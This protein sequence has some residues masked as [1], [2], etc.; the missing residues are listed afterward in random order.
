VTAAR[1]APARRGDVLR[2]TVLA[3]LAAAPLSFGAVHEAA[4]VPL[5]VVA[6]VLGVA[7]WLRARGAGAGAG[8]AEPLPGARALLAMHGLVLLQLVPLPPRALALLSPGSFSFYNDN[9]ALPLT[10]WRPVSVSPPD[11]LRGLLF[12]AGMSCL[13]AAVFREFRATRWRRRLCGTLV[14]VAFVMT[15]VALVQAAAGTTRIYGLFQ[16]RWDWAVFGPYV[17]KNHFAG[18][19]VLA[20]PLALAFAAEAL[21]GLRAAWRR[22]RVGWLAL[23]EAEGNAAIRRAAEAMALMVGLL[24]SRSRGGLVAFVV[25]AASFPLA[26]RRR[27]L[28][29]LVIALVTLLGTAWV[30]LAGMVSHFERR[31]LRSSRLQLWGDVLR[32][33][34]PFLPLGS[35]LNG[36]GILYPFHQTLWRGEWYGEAHNEYLQALIDMGL[37]G[38]LLTLALVSRLLKAAVRAAPLSALDAGLLGSVIAS[39]A[40]AL[41]DFNWQIPANAATFVA[42]A[43]LVLGGEADRARI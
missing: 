37:P 30:G 15:I 1:A 16:P 28:A 23:G 26:F 29:V 39:C 13:Y 10:E 27:R 24:A 11:T 18:Y 33:A 3:L 21:E 25:S 9:L 43:G 8:V 12:L 36:F 4:W 35:G 14:A 20:I 19:M 41:L 7:S 38:A 5:L 17:N 40:H 22:R 34:P 31:G 6:G 32:M 42:L 2:F